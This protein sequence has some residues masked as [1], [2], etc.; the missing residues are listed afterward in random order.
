MSP[1]GTWPRST[2][3][4]VPPV[5]PDRHRRHLIAGGGAGGAPGQGPC[6]RVTAQHPGLRDLLLRRSR[7]RPRALRPYWRTT[8]KLC[9]MELLSERKV[10]QFA[11]F[12]DSQTMSLIDNVRAAGRGGG[13]FNLGKLLISC[14]NTITGKAT[15]GQVCDGELQEQL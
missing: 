6:L 10:R 14:T 1:S 2:A 13:P 15:F 5:R 9:T 11:P 4:H 8:R 7:R 3:G 12:R